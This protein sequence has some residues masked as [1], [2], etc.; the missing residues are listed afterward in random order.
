[1]NGPGEAET[2]FSEALQDGRFCGITLMQADAQTFSILRT[3]YIMEV[4]KSIKK[5]FLSENLGI[6]ADPNTIL[7][8]SRY[9]GAHSALKS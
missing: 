3:E 8:A 4:T 5:R 9:P 7:N 6:T 1:M 2:K